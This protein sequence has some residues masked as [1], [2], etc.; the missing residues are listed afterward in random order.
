MIGGVGNNAK[1]E[2]F[3]KRKCKEICCKQLIV[4]KSKKKGPGRGGTVEVILE[5]RKKLG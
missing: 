2:K 1:K 4:I 3:G 5:A